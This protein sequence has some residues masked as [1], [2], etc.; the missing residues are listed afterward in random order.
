MQ[1]W[2][3]KIVKFILFVTLFFIILILA[4]TFIVGYRLSKEYHEDLI[5]LKNCMVDFMVLNEGVFPKSEDELIEKGLL[6]KKRDVIFPDEYQYFYC[7]DIVK[8]TKF[9]QHFL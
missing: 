6:V 7:P 4:D 5:N 1:I 2:K 9:R 3:N 8:N